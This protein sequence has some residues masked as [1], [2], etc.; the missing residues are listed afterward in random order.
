MRGHQFSMSR[1]G[2]LRR[3]L[4]NYR[5]VE[6]DGFIRPIEA[7]AAVIGLAHE[8]EYIERALNL[9]LSPQEVRRIGLPMTAE[10]IRRAR[11][12]AGGTTLAGRLALEYGIASNAAGGGHHA[13]R[14]RGAGYSIFN[15]VA[16]AALTLLADGVVRSVIILDLDVHQGDG[17]AEIFEDD[18][19]VFT[20]SIHAAKN[21]PPEKA[22][23]DLDIELPDG[24]GDAE[25]LAALEQALEHLDTVKA[26]LVFLNSGVDIVEADRLGGFLSVWMAC[27][28]GMRGFLNGP[29]AEGCRWPV[30][31][32]AAMVQTRRKSPGGI[33]SSS[34]R[35]QN[36]SGELHERILQQAGVSHC[37]GG[38]SRSGA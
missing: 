17:T 20:V 23:S 14:K 16:V 35:G 5:L 24:A 38:A 30:L 36:C 21:F 33:W 1:Y 10:V 34:R 6:P 9:Q 25:Y 26:D 15:D 4:V 32:G 19:R 12:T 3:D 37:S 22:I 7:G 28:R 31:P 13:N 2:F 27:E 8:A 29:G 18:E 11:L